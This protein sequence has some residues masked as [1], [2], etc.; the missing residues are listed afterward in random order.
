MTNKTKEN[1]KFFDFDADVSKVLQLMAKSLYINK[2]IFL[3]ELISN[4]S[5]ACN[6]LRYDAIKEPN[7]LADDPNLKITIKINKEKNTITISD[8]GIGMNDKDLMANLGTIAS[9]GTQK[10]LETLKDKKN[11]TKDFIGQFGVG[12]YSVFMVSDFVTVYSTKAKNKK[13]FVWSSDGFGKYSL[14]LHDKQLPRGTIVELEIKKDNTNILEDYNIERIIKLYSNHVA[15]PITLIKNDNKESVVNKGSAIWHLSK[16]EITEEQ[17]TEFYRYTSNF[18]DKPWL[19]I[20]N[21]IEGSVGYT[22]LFYVPGSSIYNILYHDYKPKIKL[23][24]KRVFISDEVSDIIPNYLRFLCG[25][26]DAEDLPLNISR[27]TLQSN[28]NIIKIKKSIT[29]KVL[30]AIEKSQGQDN[31]K[32][33][34]KNFGAVLKEGLLGGSELDKK[35]KILELCRFYSTESEKDPRSL[36]EYI[37]NMKEGQDKIYYFCGE[38]IERLRHHSQLEGFKKHNIE[39]LLL[40]DRIDTF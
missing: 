11:N 5:D 39:V 2:D 4:A 25:V 18:Y 12:F 30:S 27:E 37:A 40:T 8:N 13:T 31:Y 20:K 23:Y 38:N 15:F 22:S 10:F 17:N 32:D 7:L 34:W 19:T 21:K 24:I 35:D 6:K 1:I 28:L 9:S 33:F 36:K 29:N 14:N 3:R 26:I 16:S